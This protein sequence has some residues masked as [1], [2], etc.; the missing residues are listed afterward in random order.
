[1]ATYF[2]HGNTFYK[3]L[4]EG[5]ASVALGET[6]VEIKLVSSLPEGYTES[7]EED[8]TKAVAQSIPLAFV[9]GHPDIPPA[10]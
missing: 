10:E 3:A 1:M 4:I 9:G 6:S 8:Y 2:R 5:F 7:K